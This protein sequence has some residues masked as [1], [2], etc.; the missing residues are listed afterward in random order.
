M[1][2]LLLLLMFLFM[3]ACSNHKAQ[4]QQSE[5]Q[6]Q[7]QASETPYLSSAEVINQ[8]HQDE[9]R[10]LDLDNSLYIKLESGTVIVE[11]EPIH[12]P[13]HVKNTKALVREGLFDNT[14][15]YRVIDGFVAQ[16]G[17][18]TIEDDYQP[19]HGTL[20]I[21]SEFSAQFDEPLEFYE[22]ESNDGY[23]DR[24]GY[25]NGFAIGQSN[26][27]KESW[28]LHCYGALGMGRADETDSGGTELY[29][30]IGHAQ[31]YLDKNVT[32][33]G[34]VVYGMEHLQS[35]K[36]STS[37]SGSVDLKNHNR[38]INIQVASD[39][40]PVDLI[41]IELLKTQSNS[42]A[43][44]IEARKNRR[45]PWFVDSKNYNDVC[46]IQVPVRLKAQ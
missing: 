26:D 29:V 24:V 35:L 36:R 18:E 37:L 27:Q 23:A 40:D 9:W 20:T 25:Y 32:V 2:L 15:F 3:Y 30:V 11:L 46:S 12:T 41:P 8:S 5:I 1:K 10:G 6:T 13:N 33:F 44:Y 21:A 22:L 4:N 45:E 43:Q 17:P 42:F 7:S 14:Q 38:I 34:R 31:R 19:A 28:L 39:I 16:G